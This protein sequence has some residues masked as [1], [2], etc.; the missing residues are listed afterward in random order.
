MSA[1]SLF[2]KDDLERLLD[3]F[4]RELDGAGV[5]GSIFLV[6][7]AALSLYYFDRDT[8]RDIDAALPHDERVLSV[9]LKIA[10]EENLAENWI[11]ADATQFFGFPPLGSWSIVKTIGNVQVRVA[12]PQMLLAMKLRAHRGRRDNDDIEELLKICNIT[13]VEEV[14]TIYDSIYSQDVLNEEA[15]L[16]VLSFLKG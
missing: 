10:K 12:S 13:S 7:G 9:I 14:E 1:E 3:K 8:T 5:K 6:G 11:N 16:I 2:S 4:T 15:R